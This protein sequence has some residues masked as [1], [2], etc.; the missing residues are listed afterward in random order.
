M[1]PD[2]PLH[3]RDVHGHGDA[4]AY[5]ISHKWMVSGQRLTKADFDLA[6]RIDSIIVAH[7]A[8][9]LDEQGR[10]ACDP[11]AAVCPLLRWLESKAP[12]HKLR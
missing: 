10:E 9:P 8:E 11:A 2:Q 12:F 7:L 1:I 5:Q 6:R 4:V 3:V